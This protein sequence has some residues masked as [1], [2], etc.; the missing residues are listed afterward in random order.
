MP[1]TKKYNSVYSLIELLVAMVVGLILIGGTASVYLASKRSYIEVEM[2]A[3][4]TQNG[5]FALQMVSESLLHAGH[6]G[7]S[8]VGNIRSDNDLTDPTNDCT[9]TAATY[10]AEHYLVVE[11]PTTAS[12]FGGCIDDVMPNTSVLVIKSVLPMKLIDSD[13]DNDIDGDDN[14]P[15]TI[16]ATN[17]YVMTNL[18]GGI[19]FNGGDAS[20]P[21]ITVGGDV[22]EGSAWVYQLQ[23]YYIRDPGT[24]TPEL[25]RKV[26]VNNSLQ[27]EVLVEGIENMSFLF[28]LD[29]DANGDIDTYST[30]ANVP[31]TAWNNISSIQINLLVR[32]ETTDVNYTNT[33]VY[34]LSGLAANIG[35]L[36]DNFHRTVMQSTVLLRNPKFVIRGNTL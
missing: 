12:V 5:R 11:I 19:I 32:A 34:N 29:S 4:M 8:Q 15:E 27:T 22:S 21:S 30:V 2:M 28:G 9:D 6:F 20:P 3:R 33:K 36:N 16:S 18:S 13:N 25:A 35:P 1:K 24:G 23:I 17:T 26:L 7:E 31:P 10:D 14:N